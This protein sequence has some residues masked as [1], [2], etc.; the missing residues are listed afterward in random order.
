MAIKSNSKNDNWQAIP[1]RQ[2]YE[3]KLF[4]N[5]LTTAEKAAPSI[6][7]KLVNELSSMTFN[8]NR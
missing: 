2:L 6:T 7:K 3:A 5:A 8:S 1:K 4:T